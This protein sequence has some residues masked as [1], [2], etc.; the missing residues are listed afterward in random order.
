[1]RRGDHVERRTSIDVPEYQKS[2]TNKYKTIYFL[3]SE[4]TVLF[5]KFPFHVLVIRL[6]C[7]YIYYYYIN[8]NYI[9]LYG[10]TK[11]NRKCF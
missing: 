2:A 10:V 9:S 1:M 11:L 7:V 6:I 8:I 3:F 4:Q 5:Y